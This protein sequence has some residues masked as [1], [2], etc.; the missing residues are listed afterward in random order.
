MHSSG[1]IISVLAHVSPGFWLGSW[2]LFSLDRQ[3]D[4]ACLSHCKMQAAKMHGTGVQPASRFA[5]QLFE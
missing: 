5:V 1:E 4:C 3:Q 2:G